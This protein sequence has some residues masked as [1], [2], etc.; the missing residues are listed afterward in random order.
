M[1]DA[2]KVQSDLLAQVHVSPTPR[3][4]LY[5]AAY[6]VETMYRR[7]VAGRTDLDK[8]YDDMMAEKQ[9]ILRAVLDAHMAEHPT[10]DRRAC[11]VQI[12]NAQAQA[13]IDSRLVR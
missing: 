4:T 5:T 9:S 12:K 8:A 13:E 11:R 1:V 3:Y 7:Y 10:D 6:T 2:R